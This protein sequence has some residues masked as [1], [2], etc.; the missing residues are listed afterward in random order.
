MVLCDVALKPDTQNVEKGREK[1]IR[2]IVLL[3]K[4]MCIA[5][6]I[7]MSKYSVFYRKKDILLLFVTRTVGTY[8]IQWKKIELGNRSLVQSWRHINRK[9]HVLTKSI[10]W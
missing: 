10:M 8:L 4:P 7:W 6:C 5:A 1:A 3:T 2:K 9:T